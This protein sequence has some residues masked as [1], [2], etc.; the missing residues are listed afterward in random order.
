VDPRQ[1]NPGQNEGRPKK[2]GRAAPRR[3][4]TTGRA[5]HKYNA[6]GEVDGRHYQ[7]RNAG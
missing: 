6:A 2:R 3:T 5:S 4:N 1:E 7:K